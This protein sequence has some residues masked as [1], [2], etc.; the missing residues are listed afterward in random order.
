M[1]TV[2]VPHRAGAKVDWKAER[3]E[4]SEQIGVRFV[5]GGKTREVSFPKKSA[6]PQTPT[7]K[8]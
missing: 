2:M 5:S 7:V 4:T 6:K 8:P 1:L 3:I